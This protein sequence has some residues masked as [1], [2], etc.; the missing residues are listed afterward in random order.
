[1]GSAEFHTTINSL[2]QVDNAGL[3][4]VVQTVSLKNRSSDIY[5][6][7][8]ALEIGS[9]NLDQI[10]ANDSKNNPIPSQVTTTDN[11][12][13][14]TLNF[15]HPVVGKD[16]TN[17]FFISYIN[18]DVARLQGKV[19][20]VNI[21]LI[22]NLD[23]V[24][25]T[26]LTLKVPES[27]SLPSIVNP[28]GYLLKQ[29]PGFTLL[30]FSRDQLKSS[31]VS[32]LFGDHQVFSFT[33]NYHL[34][35]STSNPGITQIALPP[36]T[37]YQKLYYDVIEPKPEK[38]E[39]DA[40]GNWLATYTL[41]PK[42]RLDVV[43]QGSA[44]IFLSSTLPLPDYGT[45]L[46]RYLKDTPHWPSS[47]SQIQTLAQELN[48]PRAIYDYLVEN[49]TYDYTQI[50]SISSERLGAKTA[51]DNPNEATCQEFTDA[52]IALARAANIPAREHT[53]YAYTQNSR[54][55]PLSLIQDVLH[56]WPEYY[57]LES[58]LW[59]SIDPTWGNTTGGVNYFDILDLNHFTFAIHGLDSQSPFPAGY[60]KYE[61][62]QGQDVL[63]EFSDQFPQTLTN[64]QVDLS[65]PPFHLLS[66]PW[67]LNLTLK[68][69]GNTAFYQLPVQLQISP[70]YQLRSENT[71]T[72]KSL[73]P[74]SQITHPVKLT[75]TSFASNPTG[76]LTIITSDQILKHDLPTTNTYLQVIRENRLYLA[77]ILT[78]IALIAGGLLV[79]FFKR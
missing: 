73:L 63:I 20:E 69:Q 6:T 10:T 65:G 35:N 15:D 74:F 47:D 76:Q 36:D 27:Y 53:G 72:I 54:L 58:G 12:T 59:R 4:T 13:V 26:T 28:K 34:E 18:P 1:M 30:E 9:T 40:D 56:S 31:G 60:Y 33:I 79:R 3:A 61:D 66:I 23:E 21:P 77:I 78:L 44:Q 70:G 57:D 75:P 29:E 43:A 7:Q 8:Y 24:E 17:T 32:A 52:F 14:I 71:F 11:S 51:L 5:A 2:Y 37:P 55:R 48:T 42:T 46:N 25:D 67:P 38:L 62:T 45:D 50:D 64:F 49:F 41:K 19:L 68:N 39:T 16:Q 22:G